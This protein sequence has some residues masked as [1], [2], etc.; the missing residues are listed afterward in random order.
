MP[1]PNVS[2]IL[3]SSA[4]IAGIS[5]VWYDFNKKVYESVLDL[6]KRTFCDTA[7]EKARRIKEMEEEIEEEIG[8]IEEEEEEEA[9]GKTD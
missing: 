8:R 7:A 6:F 1:K 4:A 5:I 2:Q 9:A 3:I